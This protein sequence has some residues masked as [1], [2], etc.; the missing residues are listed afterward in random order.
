MGRYRIL[1]PFEA[2][3]EDGRTVGVRAKPRALLAALLLAPGTVL[4]AERLADAVWG[5]TAPASARELI[6]LYVSQL[7]E[8]LGEG[9]IETRAGGYAVPAATEVDAA[10]FLASLEDARA[11]RASGNVELALAAIDRALALWRGAIVL[12]DTPLEGD[13]RIAA[14]LLEDARL[15]ALEDRFEL[16]L[17]VRPAH[18][19]VAK[20]ES[21]VTAFPARE[22]LRRLLMLA[23]YR[24]GRQADALTA[25]RDGRQHLA[26]EYGLEPTQELRDLE[27]AILRQDPSLDAPQPPG[28][29][30]TL[31]RRGT[32]AVP[33]ALALAAAAAGAAAIAAA[34]AE[35]GHDRVVV[36]ADSLLAIDPRTGRVTAAIAMPDA[37]VAA[38]VGAGLVYVATAA[39]TLVEI[40]PRAD[41]VVSTIGL[42]KEPHAVAYAGGSVWVGNDEDGTLTRIGPGGLVSPPELPEPRAE[43]RLSFAPEDHGLW[44]G[45]VDNVAT[46]LSAEGGATMSTRAVQPQA[47]TVAF[48]SLWIA[49]ATRVTV[50]RIDVR[51]G[52]TIA[53][54][55]VGGPT[56]SITA[57]G[58]AVWA[59]TWGGSTLW[60]I[61]PRTDAVVA[62]IRVKPD[63]SAVAVGGSSVWVVAGA[64]GTLQLVDPLRNRVTRTIDV[65]RA[66]AAVAGSSRVLWVGVR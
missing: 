5:E 20:L 16:A 38:A 32:R 65:G 46:H 3:S 31:S 36:R 6:R 2:L 15:A 56:S 8:S 48:G 55:P 53:L 13:A 22:R 1:G 34:W 26:E 14:R 39:H 59:L 24:S 57:S 52:R 28:L 25:Y 60:R 63:A 45:S 27:R 66:I 64:S 19:S 4:S 47:M 10:G 18:E 40:D 58:S 50:R 7:R 42:P 51:T 44:V 33:L 62:A 11:A 35:G 30:A 54:I 9:A 12:P 49:Q 43:G 61:D 21:L 29:R 41:H 17:S 37:P 23:L